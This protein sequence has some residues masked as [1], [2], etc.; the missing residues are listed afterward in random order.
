ML[1]QQFLV[2]LLAVSHAASAQQVSLSYSN[3]VSR[4]YDF[5]ALA[6]PPLV[7]EKCGNWTSHS[8]ACTYDPA[9][10]TY[11]DWYDNADGNGYITNDGNNYVVAEMNGPG[12]IWRVW[13]ALPGAGSD[14]HIY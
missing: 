8:R 12:V 10:D 6:T 4:L 11:Q 9:T 1:K 13:S 7:G 14:K 5:K 2:V 3:I